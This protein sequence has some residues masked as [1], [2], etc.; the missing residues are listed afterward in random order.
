MESISCDEIMNPDPVL[1]EKVAQREGLPDA[2]SSLCAPDFQKSCFGCC[3]PIRPSQWD[4]LL[5]F[6]SLK[7]EFQENRW[8]FFQHSPVRR[9]I[10]G[11]SC[12]A[13]GYLDPKGRRVG[14][15]L[16]PMR[17][18]GRDLRHLTGYGAKCSREQ[19]LASRIFQKMSPPAQRF[20][21]HLAEGLCTFYYSSPKANPLFHVL[22]WGEDVLEA[23][24]RAAISK[25][26]SATELVWKYPF[27]LSEQWRPR[28][29]RF[30]FEMVLLFSGI[31]S[32]K[33]SAGR[34]AD[35]D[36]A[37]VL[38][39]ENRTLTDQVRKLHRFAWE[40]ITESLDSP[41]NTRPWVYLHEASVRASFADYF[42][43]YGGRRKANAKLLEELERVVRDEAL[44][45]DRSEHKG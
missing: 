39:P 4:P 27:L 42:R 23:L 38:I 17:H 16:H 15:L 1:S 29:D 24:A 11:Y 12:W 20:W 34:S 40:R 6:R 3:P 37:S 44:K 22:L 41:R 26:W 28:A 21:L 14:C 43:I 7:R 19:C 32:K 25:A 9:P 36:L 30:L 13:L 10:V 45:L 33:M 8:R 5:W 18:D 35:S 31:T 2:P